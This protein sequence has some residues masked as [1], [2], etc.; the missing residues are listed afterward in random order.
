M[1]YCRCAYFVKPIKRIVAVTAAPPIL[2]RYSVGPS[3]AGSS[4]RVSLTLFK[5]LDSTSMISLS[6]SADK[7][8]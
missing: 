8:R 2:V 6:T 5:G 4:L 3:I 1:P 7:A